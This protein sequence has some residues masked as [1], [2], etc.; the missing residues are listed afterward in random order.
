MDCPQ[1][2]FS[3]ETGRN[4][5]DFSRCVIEK[6]PLRPLNLDVVL[7]TPMWPVENRTTARS[8]YLESHQPTPSGWGEAS[9]DLF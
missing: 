6:G 9:L 4:G 7:Q 5:T 8:W 3:V 2:S 1:Q